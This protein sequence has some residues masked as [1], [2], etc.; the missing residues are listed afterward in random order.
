VSTQTNLSAQGLS[1]AVV[2]GGTMGVGIVY[3]YAAVGFNVWLVEPDD[4]RAK[5]V[6]RTLADV[7]LAGVKRGKLSEAQAR[8][9]VESVQRRTSIA[10]MPE[11]FATPEAAEAYF[12][13]VLAPFGEL[14]DAQWSHL[15]RH[16][17]A[18]DAAAGHFKLL[19]DPG[20]ARAFRVPWFYSLNLWKYWEAIPGPVQVLHGAG[21][22]LLTFE[23]SAEMA[24][25]NRNVSV[26]HFAECGHAPPLMEARQIDPVVAFLQEGRR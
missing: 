19:C 25:R 20:I 15:T 14:S 7:S 22:D 5:V 11:G 1:I 17:V 4:E 3:V 21:S 23:L 18:W 16:G 26:V 9:V 6:R 2:G 24:A 10:E 8:R 12:R 13:S